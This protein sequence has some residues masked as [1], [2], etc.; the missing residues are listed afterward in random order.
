MNEELLL[1][2]PLEV[3]IAIGVFFG[4]LGAYL[5]EK[6]GRS[7]SLGFWIGFLFGFLGLIFMFFFLKKHKDISSKN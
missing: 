4:A 5:S 3:Y 6:R 7:H 2:F 1:P